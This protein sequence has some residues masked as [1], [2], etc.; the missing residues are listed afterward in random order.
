MDNLSTQAFVSVVNKQ[1]GYEDITN[2]K[3]YEV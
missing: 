2:Q 3:T 1:I